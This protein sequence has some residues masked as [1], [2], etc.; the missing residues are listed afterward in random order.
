MQSRANKSSVTL[1]DWHHSTSRNGSSPPS[2]YF[3][4]TGGTGRFAGATGEGTVTGGDDSS[5]HSNYSGT[6]TIGY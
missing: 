6:G 4:N 5:G 3:A 1:S 2:G